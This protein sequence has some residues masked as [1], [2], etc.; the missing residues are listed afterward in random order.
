MNDRLFEGRTDGWFQVPGSPSLKR[1]SVNHSNGMIW[2]ITTTNAIVRLNSTTGQWFND[3]AGGKGKD[4]CS[5]NNTC[6]VIGMDDY[7]W[8]GGG[9]SGWGRIAGEGKAKRIALDPVNGPLWV[10]GMNDGIW[11]YDGNGGWNEHP[12]EGRG[13]DVLSHTGTPFI[14]GSDDNVWQSAGAAGWNHLNVVEGS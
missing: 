4:I 3:P 8:E 11:S 10:I 14:I 2:G 5:R 9:P 1:I 7:I 12:W 6:Y 13:K